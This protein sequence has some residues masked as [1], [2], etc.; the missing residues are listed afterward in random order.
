MCGSVYYKFLV[1]RLLL[2]AAAGKGIHYKFLVGRLSV[3]WYKVDGVYSK[4]YFFSE[5]FR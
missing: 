3:L 1:A 5:W 2:A 4:I